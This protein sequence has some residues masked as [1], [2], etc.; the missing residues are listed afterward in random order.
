M[1]TISRA[2]YPVT[3]LAVGRRAPPCK[4]DGRSW[5]EATPCGG[6]ERPMCDGLILPG[7]ERARLGANAVAMI[8]TAPRPPRA[9][10]SPGRRCSLALYDTAD[11]QDQ[12]S[13]SITTDSGQRFRATS[14]KEGRTTVQ[15]H[16]A[17]QPID[18]S[19]ALQQARAALELERTELV[20]HEQ[21]ARRVG[22][23]ARHERRQLPS[24]VEN[25]DL[26]EA[27]RK[28]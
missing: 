5:I 8:R 23:D 19:E 17:M 18:G 9:S 25:T 12:S 20:E 16:C 13:T 26:V 22:S 7:S 24:D 3:S 4:T 28:S 2:E 21:V 1:Q 10:S 6:P 11:T 15:D 27:Q 14:S